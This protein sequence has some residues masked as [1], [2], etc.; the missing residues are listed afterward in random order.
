MPTGN[1]DSHGLSWAM[2]PILSGVPCSPTAAVAARERRLAERLLEDERLRRGLDD[3]TWQPIQ[4]WLLQ[5][6]TLAAAATSGLSDAAADD[7]LDQASRVLRE[8]ARLLV[9]QRS[10][11]RPEEPPS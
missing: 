6:A 10:D 8:L 3:E 1:S 9:S 11:A 7:V 5:G 4:D 2:V